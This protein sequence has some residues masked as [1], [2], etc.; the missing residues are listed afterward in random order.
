MTDNVTEL[1]PVRNTNST[2]ED[3]TNRPS[4]LD[5][6]DNL[7]HAKN[8]AMAVKLAILGDHYN[9]AGGFVGAGEALWCLIDHHIDML[10]RL[11]QDAEQVLEQEP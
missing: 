9:P 7:G 10:T 11:Q 2:T 8:H 6:V 5:L 1:R 4:L 3:E